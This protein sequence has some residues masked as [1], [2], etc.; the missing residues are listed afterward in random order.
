M[1]AFPSREYEPQ[2]QAAGIDIERTFRAFLKQVT[3]KDGQHVED[4]IERAA[5]APELPLPRHTAANCA[6]TDR[7]ANCLALRGAGL[8]NEQIAQRLGVGEESVKTYVKRASRRLKAHNTTHAVALA[9]SL[10]LIRPTLELKRDHH[11][12]AA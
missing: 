7:E 12:L 11:Q 6:L 8:T 3:G 4:L 10:G 2:L 1:R 5:L 9:L